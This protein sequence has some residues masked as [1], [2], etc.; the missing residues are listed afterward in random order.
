MPERSSGAAAA[1]KRRWTEPLAR[2]VTIGIVN[3]AGVW[4]VGA[5]WADT[6]SME[7]NL[8][9]ASSRRGYEGW[10]ERPR[11]GFT[12]RAQRF[13][14]GTQFPLTPQGR[15]Q[16]CSKPIGAARCSSTRRSSRNRGRTTIITSSMRGRAFPI[17]AH[18]P[19]PPSSL[20]PDGP[21]EAHLPSSSPT[22][23]LLRRPC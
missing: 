11:S 5:R 7:R 4:A 13:G 9:V 2:A 12:A 15:L 18:L 1:D 20:S 16:A 23:E 22:P 14:S 3:E 17:R 10:R 21:Q 6:R 8:R 19:C